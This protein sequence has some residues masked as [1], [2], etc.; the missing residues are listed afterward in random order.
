VNLVVINTTMTTTTTRVTTNYLKLIMLK[1]WKSTSLLSYYHVIL[2]GK[3]YCH[4]L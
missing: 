1:K 2:W 3:Y 4:L